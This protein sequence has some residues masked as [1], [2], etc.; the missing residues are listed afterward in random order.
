MSVYNL[1]FLKFQL[2]V[3]RFY[4]LFMS[5]ADCTGEDP[6]GLESGLV[7]NQQM[8][9][10][11]EYDKNH[12]PENARLNFAEARGK[13]GSWSSRVNDANQWLQV[14]FLQ[15]V[16]IA[17]IATQGRQNNYDQWVTKYKIMYSEDGPTSSTFKTYQENGQDKVWGASIEAER[18]VKSF[19]MLSSK[20]KKSQFRW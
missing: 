1:T 12:G 10:S 8:T 17:K 7:L 13:V 3:A 6:F 20:M 5:W 2:K 11:S 9:A 15:N 4:F 18:H 16:K 19:K 14:D